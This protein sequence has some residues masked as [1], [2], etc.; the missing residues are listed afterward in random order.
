M[1]GAAW[2][3]SHRKQLSHVVAE[4]Q[5]IKLARRLCK[6]AKRIKWNKR[7]QMKDMTDAEL[8]EELAKIDD[9]LYDGE[10]SFID[11]QAKRAAK[12]P[13]GFRL[14][15]KQRAWAERIWDRING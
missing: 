7:I 13:S 2:S 3:G 8:I 6:R 4:L 9:G 15:V 12:Y 5:R 10:V 14:S 11:E 1:S